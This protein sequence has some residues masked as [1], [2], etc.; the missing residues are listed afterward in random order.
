MREVVR[1][2]LAR[3]CH[4]RAIP[5][6]PL[7]PSSWAADLEGR[8]D[9]DGGAWPQ[10]GRV[11]AGLLFS[12]GRARVLPPLSL[13]SLRSGSD[14]QD[15]FLTGYVWSAVT[16]SP[17]HLGDEVNLK[18]TVLCDSLQEPL[19]FTC[20]CKS[21]GRGGGLPG[22]GAGSL[23]LSSHPTVWPRAALGGW[24]WGQ[25]HV[26]QP[27]TGA[28]SGRRQCWIMLSREWGTRMGAE[29]RLPQHPIITA[30]PHPSQVPPLWTCS[31]TRPCA[32]PVTN[33]GVWMWATL[34]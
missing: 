2:H 18:V 26:L 3:A 6:P 8:A 31:S 22:G 9:W 10:G 5:T 12:E 16:P 20:N 27:Q 25:G 1:W 29:P 30:L 7:P 14:V 17:E 21:A 23:S 33:C 13:H 19:T 15:Y 32:T 34:C 11:P 28:L 4:L 24:L